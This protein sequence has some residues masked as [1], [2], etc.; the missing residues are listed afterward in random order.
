MASTVTRYKVL[1]LVSGL[2]FAV[3]LGTFGVSRIVKNP[4]FCASCHLMKPEFATWKASSHL[5]VACVDCHA[6]KKLLSSLMSGKK[7]PVKMD[8]LIGNDVCN[9]CHSSRREITPSGDLIVPHNKHAA[10][11]VLCMN[12]HSGV[13]HG[14]IAA[15]KV[16]ET[17]AAK[18]WTP[19]F[20]A[21]QMSPEFTEPKM[22][23]C[24]ECHIKREVTQ[25]CQACHTSISLPSDHK[26]KG[27][28][29]THG[30]KARAD[31]AYCN[32]CHSYSLDAKDVPVKDQVARYARGNVFCYDCHQNRPIG[33]GKEWKM[34]HKQNITNRDVSGCVVCHNVQKAEI[35][36]RAVPTYCAKCH[37]NQDSFSKNADSRTAATFSKLHPPD[38][39]KIHP[40][41]V[42]EKGVVNEGCW[43]CHDT[44]HC[45]K[46]HT[47]KL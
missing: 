18:M 41:I 20:G 30:K 44:T 31:L 39:R 25:E 46:C 45:S 23:V 6:A 1:I 19:E 16:T 21:Q 13:G 3:L 9:K 29:T 2:I 17:V 32:K 10:K 12:C 15:R 43:D 8:E 27:W 14:N 22:N 11:N 36:E 42:K 47:N 5:Q 24:L 34:V 4:E 33:H 28:G 7:G 38:W 37:G 40:E 26:E 35:Q